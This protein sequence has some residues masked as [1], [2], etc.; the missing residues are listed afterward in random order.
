MNLYMGQEISHIKAT[1]AE[2]GKTNLW[3]AEQS[4]T[5]KMVYQHLPTGF[6]HTLQNRRVASG[7]PEGI[8]TPITSIDTC[9]I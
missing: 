9:K 8:I 5:K 1:P 7:K 3:L 4:D 2:T 6:I